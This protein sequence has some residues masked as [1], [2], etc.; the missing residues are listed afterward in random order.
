MK[1]QNAYKNKPML[2]DPLFWLSGCL[3]FFLIITIIVLAVAG[4]FIYKSVQKSNN[5]S[6]VTKVHRRNDNRQEQRKKDQTNEVQEENLE[7]AKLV[8]AEFL[9]AFMSSDANG[10]KKLLHGR[11]YE[12]FNPEVEFQG[13]ARPIDFS[14][15]SSEALGDANYR[16]DAN[17]SY[18]DIQGNQFADKWE[19]IVA[20]FDDQFLITG[21]KYL[22]SN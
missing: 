3:G 10:M 15:N 20:K 12:E 1:N 13:D 9:N 4:F 2:K 21:R 14:V 16:V 11:A 19:F 18:G 5:K 7:T 22:S 17:I 8:V 6:Q